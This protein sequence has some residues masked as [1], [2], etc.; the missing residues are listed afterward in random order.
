MSAS[1]TMGAVELVADAEVWP[2]NMAP[3][4]LQVLSSSW[5]TGETE[6]LRFV[7]YLVAPTGRVMLR[8]LVALSSQI[9]SPVYLDEPIHP[10]HL[11]SQVDFLHHNQQP[12]IT[13]KLN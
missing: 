8:A 4:E 1:E 5:A 6:A 12:M 9:L 7:L 3:W 11:M 2:S 13:Q 10:L